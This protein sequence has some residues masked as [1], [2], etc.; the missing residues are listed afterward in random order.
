MARAVSMV[1]GLLAGYAL[2]VLAGMALVTVFSA[3]THDKS[4]EMAMTAAFA[5]GPVG[6]ITGLLVALM[7][8]RRRSA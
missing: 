4:V 2:G 3:N 8:G 5:T 6:A 1:V 7:R